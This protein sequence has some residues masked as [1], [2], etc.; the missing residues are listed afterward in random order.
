MA[1]NQMKG[2]SVTQ[3]PVGS[4]CCNGV[5]K[6]RTATDTVQRRSII[7]N[8]FQPSITPR[9]RR[10][11]TGASNSAETPAKMSKFRPFHDICG[12]ATPSATARCISSSTTIRNAKKPTRKDM[13]RAAKEAPMREKARLTAKTIPIA[14]RTKEGGGRREKSD[15]TPDTASAAVSAAHEINASVTDQDFNA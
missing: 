14:N 1:G 10:L 4:N 3:I 5:G 8:V 13:G 12:G 7:A 9:G 15:R 11:A 6:L 2:N